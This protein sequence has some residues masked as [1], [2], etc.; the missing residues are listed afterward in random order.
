MLTIHS[1]KDLYLKQMQATDKGS[2][3]D[4]AV[5][6]LI[7]N[8]TPDFDSLIQ[9]VS[10]ASSEQSPLDYLNKWRIV[11]TLNLIL[12]S[13]DDKTKY[14]PAVVNLIKQLSQKFFWIEFQPLNILTSLNYHLA[15]LSY[16]SIMPKQLICGAAALEWGEHWPWADIP[17]APFHAELGAL[18]AVLGKLTCDHPLVAAAIQLAEW[19]LNTLDSDF[20]PFYRTFRARIRCLLCHSFKQ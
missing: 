10:I 12:D 1:L 14:L 13:L 11:L 19:Q 17:L 8:K 20:F 9:Q 6:A 16:R 18:W 5:I 7:E 3:I 2:A 15:G 4:K